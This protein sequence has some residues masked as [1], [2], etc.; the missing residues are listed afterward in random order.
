MASTE[1]AKSV[2]M[3]AGS[4]LTGDLYKVVRITADNT[5]DLATTAIQT[6]VGI[7][8]E[9]VTIGRVFPVVLLSGRVKV[10]AGAAITVGE[11]LI[12]DATS[13]VLGVADIDTLGVN[14]MA[15]GVALQ[16]AGAAGE[17]IEMLGMPI[18]SAAS[19]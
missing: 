9:E 16:A 10:L 14:E 17:I 13:R 3:L 18:T 1:S 6:S 11:L 4:D 12:V 5:A 15:I 2:S 7:V 8:G 19:A